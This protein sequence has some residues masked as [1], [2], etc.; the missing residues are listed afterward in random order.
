VGRRAH[1]RRLNLIGIV[2]LIDAC[3][4]LRGI[5]GS[6]LV[7]L[8]SQSVI[9][10]CSSCTLHYSAV[11]SAHVR[12]SREDACILHVRGAG[13]NPR[14]AGNCSRQEARDGSISGG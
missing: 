10:A 9:P 1:A 6:R 8:N 7:V 3:S 11:S 5:L 14:R 2:F 13:V 12:F 4:E